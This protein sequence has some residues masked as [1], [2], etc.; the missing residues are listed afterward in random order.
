ML[1]TTYLGLTF[2]LC[3]Q[4]TSTLP[5]APAPSS[6]AFSRAS[7]ATEVAKGRKP[8]VLLYSVDPELSEQ[9][10]REHKSGNV[11]VALVVDENGRPQDVR[12]VKGVGMGLDEKAVEA[13]KQY[14]F[15][16]ATVEGK[17]VPMRL[18]IEVNFQTF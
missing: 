15:K 17:P 18:F 6:D 5:S 4:Q 3:L 1:A 16:P 2:A 13:V 14:R 7:E 10:R 11:N 12:V 8:P 9:A